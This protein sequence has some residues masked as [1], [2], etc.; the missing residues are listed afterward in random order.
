MTVMRTLHAVLFASKSWKDG[1]LRIILCMYLVNHAF[2][3]HV[4]LIHL[5]VKF[6]MDGTDNTNIHFFVLGRST[7]L[8]HLNV[9][10]SC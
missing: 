5:Q 8:I 9:N 6:L 7:N 1:S 10:F 3:V 2:Q 4:P